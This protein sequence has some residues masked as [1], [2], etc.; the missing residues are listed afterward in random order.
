[1]PYRGLGAPIGVRSFLRGFGVLR[2][3]NL[4]V[5]RGIWVALQ[6]FWGKPYRD[7]GEPIRIGG[8]YRDLGQLL[9]I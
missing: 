7:Y 4:G 1:M 6:E 2:R 9:K 3:R 5:P 8:G